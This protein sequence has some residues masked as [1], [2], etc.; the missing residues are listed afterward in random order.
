MAEANRPRT[1]VPVLGMHRSGTSLTTAILNALGVSLSEDLMPPTQ[2]NAIGYF[3]S[4]GIRAIQ[5]ELLETALSSSW[6]GSTTINPFPPQWWK[7]P[8]VAPFKER[9]KAHVCEDM[10]RVPGLWGFKDPRT[11]R[12]LPLW[13]EIFEEL[14]LEPRYVLTG[15]HPREVARSLAKRDGIKPLYSELLWLEHTVDAILYTKD[16]L[17]AVV[18]YSR[19][20]E[21]PLAQARYLVS[22]LGF[23]MPDESVL[24]GV[25][26]RFVSTEL[27]HH[28][29]VSE[30]CDLPFSREI[31]QAVHERDLQGMDT[32]ANLFQVAS[33]FTTKVVRFTVGSMVQKPGV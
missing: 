1:V 13:N 3:E 31:Y 7:L 29:N 11:S 16:R 21:D 12:L 20:F 10:A 27:R 9:L 4:L 19:W 15:R 26:D 5:D 8:Q 23:D 22:S 25:I 30:D 33:V 18:D 17:Q 2:A 24:R 28:A 6:M 32:L 14:N